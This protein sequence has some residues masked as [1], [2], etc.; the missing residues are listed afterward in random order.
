[1]KIDFFGRLGATHRSLRVVVRRKCQWWFRWRRAVVSEVLIHPP[2]GGGPPDLGR[3][4]ASGN[5]C[6]LEDTQPLIGI[7]GSRENSR[8]A[9]VTLP[10]AAELW[11]ASMQ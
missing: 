5:C 11:I 7:I 2:A 10:G 9:A 8:Y 6:R 3:I 1:M 4:D